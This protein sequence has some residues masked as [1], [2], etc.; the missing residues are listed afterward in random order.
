MG[1]MHTR[2]KRKMGLT[3]S[4]RHKQ[5]NG[6]IAKKHGPRTF[7]TE[8]SAHKW[9]TEHKLAKDKYSLV[10]AKKKIKF[11]IEIK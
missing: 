1:K 9:A 4:F 3:T 5:T 11:K 6:G 7:K 8:E 10:P 2:A